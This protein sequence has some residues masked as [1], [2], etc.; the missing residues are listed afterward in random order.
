[1]S[2]L[3]ITKVLKTKDIMNNLNAFIK[4]VSDNNYYHIFIENHLNIYPEERIE[5]GGLTEELD[6]I[7]A[8]RLF[9]YSKQL[10]ERVLKAIHNKYDIEL[11]NDLLDTQTK[12]NI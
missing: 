1:M 9:E 11:L 2:E 7:S 5:T 10:K 6:P 3:L 12:L 8:M 4:L